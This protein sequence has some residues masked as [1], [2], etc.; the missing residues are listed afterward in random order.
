MWVWAHWV[1]SRTARCA[2]SNDRTTHCITT[3]PCC[4]DI[5]FRHTRILLC[6]VLFALTLHCLLLRHVHSLAQF[7]L[8]MVG[9]S[10]AFFTVYTSP[11]MPH[12]TIT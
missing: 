7:F 1:V 6:A 8:M 12:F 10:A 11:G 5:I 2:R 9:S 4:Y 3:I